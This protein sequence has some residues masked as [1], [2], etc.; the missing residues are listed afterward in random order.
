METNFSRPETIFTIEVSMDQTQTWIIYE[1]GFHSFLE[2]NDRKLRMERQ[3]PAQ[4]F[5]VVEVKLAYKV[6]S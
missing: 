4:R 1:G 3:F 5:R 2:A 6:V